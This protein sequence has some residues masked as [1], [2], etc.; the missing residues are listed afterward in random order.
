VN[1]HPISLVIAVQSSAMVEAILPQVK[2]VGSMLESFIVGD[3]GE[4]AV[5]AFDHRFRELQGFTS[6]T[7]KISDALKK[8]NAGSSSSRLIDA[9]AYGIRMLRSRPA[10]RRRVLLI[11]SETRDVA[12]EGKLRDSV[13]DAQLANVSV[14]TV[15]MSRALATATYKGQPPRVDQ[16]PPANRA[17]TMPSNVVATPTTVMQSGNSDGNSANFV[18]L[19][20]EL[21]KDAKAVF[22]D[23]PAEALTKATGGQEFSFVKQK[24]LEHAVAKIGEELHSQYLITYNP[25]N[26]LEGGYHEIKV[27]VEGNRGEWKVRARPGYWLAAVPN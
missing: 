17:G 9:S 27:Q 18:P 5:L 2:K 7:S 24:A 15:N 16:M 8:I 19:L 22:R 13:L 3:Q 25:N 10:N 14:Y 21:F 20:V 26:K 6:D 23:N 4:A 11:I 12:S 1:Y